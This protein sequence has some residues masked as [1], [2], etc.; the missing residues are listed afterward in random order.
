MWGPNTRAEREQA[1]PTAGRIG[2]PVRVVS[3]GFRNK[4]FDLIQDTVDREAAK[5]TDI[6]I[7]LKTW[8]GQKDGT[9]EPVDGP[10][11]TARA[12]LA[13]KHRTYIVCPIDRMEGEGRL[14]S[15]VLL[16][17]QGNVVSIYNKVFPSRQRGQT[18]MLRIAPYGTGFFEGT[19]PPARCFEADS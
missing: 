3:L 18:L 5:G 1:A 15:T 9:A 8:R 11:V 16:D 6:V 12:T 13:R 14:N 7:L 17:R 4:P 19:W 10:T 2:R